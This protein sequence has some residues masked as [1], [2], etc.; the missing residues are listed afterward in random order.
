MSLAYCTQY[1]STTLQSPW[2]NTR[3]TAQHILR[4]EIPKITFIHQIN[5][6]NIGSIELRAIHMALTGT[7]NVM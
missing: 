5:H 4:D 3:Q 2:L 1:R 7:A 6:V